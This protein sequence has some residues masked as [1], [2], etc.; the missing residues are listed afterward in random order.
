MGLKRYREKRDF[1]KTPEPKGGRRNRQSIF[2]VQKHAARRL[3]YDFRIECGGV[4]KSW[5]VP[6]GFSAD[7]KV[8]HL[9]IQVEDHPLDYGGFEGVIPKGQ[10]GAG[11]VAIWDRGTYFAPG[12]DGK[13]LSEKEIEKKLARGEIVVELYGKKLKGA[14]VLVKRRGNQWLLFKKKDRHAGNEEGW[15][16]LSV[17]SHRTIEQVEQG[18]RVKASKDSISRL[19]EGLPKNVMPKSIRPMLAKVSEQPVERAGWSYEI[20]W[21]GYRVIAFIARGGVRLQSRN[22]KDYT[23]VFSPVASKLASI[24]HECVLDGEVVVLD[25]KGLPSFQMLQN[26]L[27]SGDGVLVYYIFDILHL[28]G[29]DL[30][31][32]GYKERRKM[33]ESLILNEGTIRISATYE[34]SGSDFYKQ[35]VLKGLEGVIA[36][37]QDS[38]YLPG[39]RSD[40]WMKTKAKKTDDLVIG[41]WNYIKGKNSGIGALLLGRYE[42]GILKFAGKVGSGIEDAGLKTRLSGLISD[43]PPFQEDVKEKGVN[44]V[45]PALVCSVEFTEKTDDGKLR[46]PVYLGLRD[47][48]SS[49]DLMKE[50]MPK[51]E[52]SARRFSRQAP[53][54]RGSEIFKSKRAQFELTHLDRVFWPDDG[55]TKK[56]L[57]EYYRSISKYILPHL[58]DRPQSLN[59]FPHGLGEGS[60]YQKNNP[61]L[62]DWATSMDLES[63]SEGEVI[64]YVYCNDISMLI[65]LVQLGCIEF[66]VWN[67]RRIKPEYPDYMVLDLDPEGIGFG[68]VVE[69]AKIAKNLLDRIG[70]KSFCKTSGATGLHIYVPLGA[71]YT[72][73]QSRLFSEALANLIHSQTSD[74]SSLERRPAKRGGKVYLDYLQNRRGQTMAAPYCV[75]PRPGATVS[76]PLEWKEVNGKL[77]PSLFEMSN[78]LKRM[79]RKGDLWKQV[80]GRGIDM[81]RCLKALA[82]SRNSA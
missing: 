27:R 36:K 82:R 46:H 23:E 45:K 4:L 59:R 13:P 32:S 53:G 71:Q 66:N 44:W 30:M 5:A 19:L 17:K 62:P 64:R 73:E 1:T 34:G 63:E 31:R 14:Y 48:L 2:V 9:A 51:G 8:K 75:R 57:V 72:H 10:Y 18:I 60:F 37:R 39:V 6:K 81:E 49:D 26:Y 76:M 58:K 16:E 25:E 21:D 43:E 7:P 52:S 22:L 42:D 74:I 12:L 54:G 61:E 38:K 70:A 68:A 65:Y 77:D 28:D 11:P 50:S 56:D 79:E 33:L 55:Y 40:G 20:K 47:D 3:H 78:A 67:S 35:A 80:L 15:T 29:R 69:I 41:G 24:E